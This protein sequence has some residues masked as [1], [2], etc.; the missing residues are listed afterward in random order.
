[1]KT[2]IIR[3]IG[4]AL[5][6]IALAA[7]AQPEVPDDRY[8]RLQTV[9][10]AAPLGTPILPGTLQ[11]DRFV[12]DGLA[13]RSQIVYVVD[14]NGHELQT[15]HYHHWTEPPAILLQD[16]FITYLRA[17]K[18]ADQ[19]VTPE[20]RVDVDHVLT[21]KVKRFEHVTGSAPKAVVE[22]ELGVR[23]V[24]DGK[25]VY[26]T[27]ERAEAAAANQTVGAGVAAMNAALG[28]IFA[29][30]VAGLKSAK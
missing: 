1:M 25:L 26:L 20:L 18:V 3:T 4:G 30:V 11:V 29:R 8:Y 2:S 23:R 22:L 5:M 27:D 24:S 13:G 17:A 19:V 10:P 7:C 15:Y 9:A 6:L 28:E 14:G 16:E 12:V 21:G